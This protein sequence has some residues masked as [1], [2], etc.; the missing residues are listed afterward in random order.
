MGPWHHHK[1]VSRDSGQLVAIRQRMRGSSETGA[2]PLR[3][4]VQAAIVVAVT[5]LTAVL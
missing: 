3:G 1:I 2:E 4:R 5:V